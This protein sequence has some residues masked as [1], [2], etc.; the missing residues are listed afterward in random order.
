MGRIVGRS[1]DNAARPRSARCVRLSR[2]WVSSPSR[3]LAGGG[4]VHR[5]LDHLLVQQFLPGDS[6]QDVRR[7]GGVADSSTTTAGLKP[8]WSRGPACWWPCAPRRG[9]PPAGKAH[10]VRQRGLRP[11]SC[12]RSA[13]S[14]SMSRLGTC[15][16]SS[17]WSS[18]SSSG[19]K[20]MTMLPPLSR[21]NFRD[22]RSWRLVLGS[23]RSKHVEVVRHLPRR[24]PSDVVLLP[25]LQATRQRMFQCF[26]I[27]VPAVAQG[28]ERVLVNLVAG[29]H[30]Q[31]QSRA[32][33]HLQDGSVN[34]AKNL[35]GEQRFAAA[36]WH[37][38][39]KSRQIA[40]RDRSCARRSC[41]GAGTCAWRCT[42]RRAWRVC[43]LL[44]APWQAGPGNAPPDQQTKLVVFKLHGFSFQVERH[45][46]RPQGALGFL[47]PFQQV[48]AVEPQF[49]AVN[50][51]LAA[52]F[53][54]I[55]LLEPGR[56]E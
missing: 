24:Q 26:A 39:A 15:S 46:H 43:C 35:R 13:S 29:H 54:L 22:S 12:P 47:F 1:P 16:F 14:S 50:H 41:Q 18:G 36:G 38:D 2:A 21:K 20:C 49:F 40:C 48:R 42:R 8:R 7:L 11:G 4:D 27:E 34:R 3:I 37:L 23:L 52:R 55:Q 28:L 9:S 17:R 56:I 10:K 5:Q 53:G 32:I 45:L 33:A 30:P 31:H 25:N 19:G 44:P 6:H 51:Q